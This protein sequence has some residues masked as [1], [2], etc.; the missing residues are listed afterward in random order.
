MH[1]TRQIVANGIE[2]FIREEGNGPLVLLCH[3]WPELSYSWRHQ[4]PALAKAGFHAVAPDIRGFGRTSAPEDVNS[5]SVF[6]KVGDMVGLVEALGEKIAVVVGHDFG[7]S[8]AWH[9]ALFRPDVFIAVAGL[10]GP[11]PIRGSRPPLAQ[12]HESGVHDFYMQHFQKVGVVEKELER[13]VENTLRTIFGRSFSWPNAELHVS[14]DRGFLGEPLADGELKLGWMDDVELSHYCESYQRSGFV[15]GLNSYRNIDRN[16]ELTAPWQDAR[17]LQPSL[18]VAG[19]RDIVL[20]AWAERVEKME[21][22]APD[23]KGKIV[24]EGAGHWIQQEC[25]NEV[26]VALISFLKSL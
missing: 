12:L 15:G 5:Y 24:I 20:T 1:T 11:P 8:L 22:V 4:L 9:C 2:Q 19:S 16:W 26:N 13:D 25:P 17:I 21:L 6:D 18:F 23:L 3:G 14:D 10:S 7:A